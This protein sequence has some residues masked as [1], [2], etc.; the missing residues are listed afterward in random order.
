MV[1]VTATGGVALMIKAEFIVL[2]GCE[3]A[4]SLLAF[5]CGAN[6]VCSFRATLDA[7]MNDTCIAVGQL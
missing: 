1:V 3:L 2:M 4:T 5:A 6:S 7:S